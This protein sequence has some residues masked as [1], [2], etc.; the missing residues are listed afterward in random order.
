MLPFRSCT[1]LYSRRF[2]S[3]VTEY[4][5]AMSRYSA[6]C[7]GN[8]MCFKRSIGTST[9]S[10]DRHNVNLTG[11]EWTVMLGLSSLCNRSVPRSNFSGVLGKQVPVKRSTIT[12]LCDIFEVPCQYPSCGHTFAVSPF[13]PQCIRLSL[14]GTSGK[15]VQSSRMQAQIS[16]LR[17]AC[18]PVSAWLHIPPP[19]DCAQLPAP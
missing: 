15:G 18:S 4:L 2:S 17:Q 6:A 14:S 13:L 16:T 12:A 1:S 10:N 8:D 19:G 11:E 3:T 9:N 7:V 5:S